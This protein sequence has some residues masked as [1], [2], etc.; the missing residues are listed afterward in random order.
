MSRRCPRPRFCATEDTSATYSALGR[1]ADAPP[2]RLAR[3]TAPRH[4]PDRYR[5]DAALSLFPLGRTS[6]DLHRPADA[7]AADQK[8]PP[9]TSW[10]PLAGPPSP[11]PRA[12]ADQPQRQI[13]RAWP[14]GR[15][16]AACRGGGLRPRGR[17]VPPARTPTM[18]PR[19]L[20]LHPLQPWLFMNCSIKWLWPTLC[21]MFLKDHRGRYLI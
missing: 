10:P 18:A 5:P 11:R 17:C 7:L 12:V 1:P 9:T 20:P 16:T 4:Q 14:P 8:P 19:S 6:P 3:F 21:E 13:P 15:R 2:W